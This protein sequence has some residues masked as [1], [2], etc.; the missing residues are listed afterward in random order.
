MLVAEMVPDGKW[1]MIHRLA[2]QGGAKPFYL[3]H[4]SLLGDFVTSPLNR[5]PGES[6]DPG[7]FK[8]T[9]FRL[10]PE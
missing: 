5:H 9:G 2:G 10:S 6:R 3:V 8:I 1:R 7:L 4:I